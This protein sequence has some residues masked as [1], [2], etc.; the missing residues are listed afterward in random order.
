MRRVIVFNHVTL[1]G[2]FTDV[3]GDMSWAHRAQQ[4]AE[5]SG[6]V[7]ENAKGESVLLFGRITYELM[8]SYWPTPA[9]LKSEPA[10]AERMNS[11]PKVVFSRTLDRASWKNTKLVKG[12]MLAE[13]RKMKKEPGPDMVI[14]G[15][16]RI[17]S[18][19]APEGL[20]DEYQIVVVPI[21]LGKGRTM[22]DGVKE[23]VTLKPTRTRAFGNGNVLLCYGFIAS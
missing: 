18:Q 23:K 8:A 13:M 11:L 10:L 19:L 12:D 2:Y 1:D 21:V 6:F 22:F 20:I 3:N 16:G 17:V 9:A 15:S 14:M 4:D 5:W 7:A